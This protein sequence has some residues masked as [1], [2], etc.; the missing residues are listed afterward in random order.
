MNWDLSKFYSS[1]DSKELKDDLLLLDQYI[2]KY[3]SYQDKFTESEENLEDFLK[4]SIEISNLIRKLLGYAQLTLATETTNKE[5]ANLVNL[6]MKKFTETQE[7]KTMSEAW[8]SSFDIDSLTSEFLKE[9]KFYLNEV[10][11]KNAHNLKPEIEAIVSK[12]NQD[13]VRAFEKQQGLL[14]STLDVPYNGKNITLSEV[15]NLAYSEDPKV[16]KAAY[17]AELAVYPAIEKSIALSLNS[18]KGY[19]NTT[20]ELRGYKS[21]LEKTLK[22]S[23]VQK[24][25]L[26]SMLEAI[27]E[28]LPT[29]R[30]YLKRKGELL[31][32]SNGLPFYDLFAPIG[33]DNREFSIEDAQSYVLDNFGTF[34]NDLRALAQKA[35]DQNWIDYYPKKGKRGGA[36]CSNIYFMKESRVL[37]NFTGSFDNVLT[38]AHELGHAYHGEKIFEES[39]LNSSYTMP[40]AET[41]SIMA[42]TIL[43]NQAIKDAG[44]NAL[45]LIESQIQDATQV[46]VDIYSRYLFEESV[47]NLRETQ[48]LDA[49]TLCDLMEQAQLNSYGDGLDPEY[50]HKYMWVPKGH[51]YS[52]GLSFYNFPYA[53]GLLFAKGLYAKY[54]EEG[55]AFVPKF[56]EL[57]RITGQNSVEDAAESVGITLDKEFW[58]NSLNVV[59]NDIETFMKLTEGNQ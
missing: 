39:M 5:A 28:T 51:Y 2:E 6:V 27:K 31:G 45:Q 30:K 41:A 12:L 38:L 33:E 47:F 23:R 3:I 42:E 20:N 29:F 13:G 26:D 10:K 37:L 54:V 36:F 59:K 49:E 8:M 4:F 58:M 22:D 55:D 34:S 18:I 50:L 21:A 46:I 44:D 16:R 56:D 17:E 7:T 11:S 15:R 53:F 24:E 14:T 52:G 1:F 19:V 35:F 9:H 43:M 48:M 25:T 40:V 57:L 32:H